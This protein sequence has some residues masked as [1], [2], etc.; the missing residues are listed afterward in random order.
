MPVAV[1]ARQPDRLRRGLHCAWRG[2]GTGIAVLG[3]PID[4]KSAQGV[5][6]GSVCT[7][8]SRNPHQALADRSAASGK[9]SAI[10]AAELAPGA[11]VASDFPR[12][13][14]RHREVDRGVTRA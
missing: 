7:W 8:D 3:H 11:L 13:R 4:A 14:R 2:K 10:P 12:V 5:V 9:R 6:R 1:E